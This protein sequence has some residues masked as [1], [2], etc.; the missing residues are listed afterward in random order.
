MMLPGPTPTLTAMAGI[1]LLGA[2]AKGAA[3]A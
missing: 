3:H 1:V 2:G